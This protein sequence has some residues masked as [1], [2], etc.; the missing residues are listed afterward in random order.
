[1][2]NVYKHLNKN[3]VTADRVLDTFGI[4]INKRSLKLE[5]FGNALKKIDNTF[6]EE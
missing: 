1:M 5:D 2:K 6:N 3:V 4:E